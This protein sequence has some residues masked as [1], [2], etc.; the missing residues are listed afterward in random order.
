MKHC[1]PSE[2]EAYEHVAKQHIEAI[3][4]DLEAQFA[5]LGGP[6]IGKNPSIQSAFHDIIEEYKFIGDLFTAACP[7]HRQIEHMLS[8]PHADPVV[9]NLHKEVAIELES[10]LEIKELEAKSH[11]A[12]KALKETRGA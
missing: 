7:V 2:Y 11:K 12:L 3:A 1:R 4:K 9:M 6:V 8:H 5:E 10:T